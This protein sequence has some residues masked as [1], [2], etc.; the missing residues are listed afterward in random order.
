[1][2]DRDCTGLVSKET[3]S[4]RSRWAI[5]YR[6]DSSPQISCD[7]AQRIRWKCRGATAF[8]L[9]GVFRA[10]YDFTILQRPGV[11]G[12]QMQHMGL[13]ESQPRSPLSELRL[14]PPR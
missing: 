7:R 6:L 3:D 12:P 10:G 13:S 14:A 5:K 2:S 11:A 1:M 8:T 9:T 4:H